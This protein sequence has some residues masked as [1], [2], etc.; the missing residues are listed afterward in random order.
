MPS[1]N[2]T[3]NL[4]LNQW[5]DTDRPMRNDFNSDNAVLDSAV[6]GHINNS[7]IHITAD[8]RKYLTD[9]QA[10]YVYSGTGES[11]KSFTLTESFRFIAVFAKGKPLAEYDSASGKTK[12]YSAFGY[13]SAGASVGLSIAASGTGFTVS[14]GEDEN[15]NYPCLNESGVQYKVV[16]FK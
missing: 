15:G 3:S 1:T 11:S 14:L 13:A 8:E 12:A 6:G 2:K 10:T 4:G 7:D 16:M 9:S 5:I